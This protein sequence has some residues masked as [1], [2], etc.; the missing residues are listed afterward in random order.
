[1]TSYFVSGSNRGI[2]LELVRLIANRP[3]TIVFAGVRN[4]SKRSELQKLAS[5]Y[6]N[7]H[8]V[9]LDSS[10]TTDAQA[11]AHTVEEIAGGLDVVIANA[12]IA[13]NWEKVVKV[14]PQ[15]LSEHFKVN[16]VGPLILFQALYPVLLKRQTRKFVTIS[17][18]VGAITNMLDVPETAYGTSKAALNFVTKRIHLEHSAE[19]FIAFPM[20]PGTVNTDMGKAA[21]PVFGLTEF[22]VLPVDSAKGI[23]AVVDAAT[24]NESGRFWNFDGTENRW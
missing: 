15:S 16:T 10:S 20:H 1:M 24:A 12:G 13:E 17:S 4:P 21:A 5:K 18:L 3:D 23:L 14:D 2:G 22:P 9:K 6:P 7:V 8:I 19:G 11:A